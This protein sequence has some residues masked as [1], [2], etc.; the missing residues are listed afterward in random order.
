MAT[1][2][3][4]VITAEQ[5]RTMP[6]PED[7]SKIELVRGEL[8]PMCRPG[9]RHGLR[10]VRVASILDH[11][12]R[13]HRHGRAVVETGVVTDRDPDTVRGPDVSY[14]SAER[15]PLDQEPEG[16][17]DI[18]PDLAV[19]VLSPSNRMV[20]VR[21]KMRELFERSVRMIWVVDPE[22]RTVTVYRSLNEGRVLHE[23]ATLQGEDMLP[24]FA[25]PV[26]DFFT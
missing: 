21:E 23:S 1:V 25:C 5:Y 3:P 6:P 22:D 17:P 8:E 26:A 9:F 12:G 20:R 16:Y 18:A 24:G 11:Y 14:W 10:Q 7:G 19:E 13:T 4:D 2:K 15:L